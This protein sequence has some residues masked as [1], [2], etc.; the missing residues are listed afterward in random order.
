MVERSFKNLFQKL[1]EKG[2]ALQNLCNIIRGVDSSADRV[3]PKSVSFLPTQK[4]EQHG[5]KNGDG[6][7]LLTENEKNALQF[8]PNELELVKPTYKNSDICPYFVDIEKNLFII[9]TKKDTQID[10]Y[11]NILN[12]LE[13]FREILESR[14][15]HTKG[16]SGW[17]ALHRPR[18][19][20]LLCSKKIVCSRWGEKGPNYFGFQTDEYYEG[21]DTRII[22][23]KDPAQEDI[24]YILA[25]LNSSLIKKWLG[26]KSQRRGY[27]AQSTLSQVPIHRINFDNPKEIKFHDEIV[28]KVKTIREK[29][30]ELAEYSKCFSDPRLTKLDFDAPLPEVNDEAI[31]KSI[32]PGNL[33]NIRTHPELKIEKPKGL[34]EKKFYLSKVEKTQPILAGKAHLKLRGKNKTSLFIEGP[35]ELLNLL[36]DILPNWKG[37]PWSEIKENLLLPDN[38]I[39]FNTQK[40]KVLD[41]VQNIRSEI[42]ELQ[43]QIDQIVYKLYELKETEIKIVEG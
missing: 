16:E 19:E 41:E 37:K 28:E 11:S 39:S 10:L 29:M 24:F 30:D 18:D 1:E 3:T 35:Y 15:E 17:Y 22:I 14:G 33:Y 34:E 25:V 6:V 12:H 21:T 9:Y 32:S 20:K 4:I 8:L 5:I 36:F 26:E 31:I 13:K 23:P 7:F 2:E 42:L 43:K 38:V 27:T 40:N